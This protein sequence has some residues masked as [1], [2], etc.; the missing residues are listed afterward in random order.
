VEK[1]WKETSW[2]RTC[3]SLDYNK[4]KSIKGT[5]FSVKRDERSNKNILVGTY[6]DRDNFGARFQVVLA[7]ESSESLNW[8]ADQLNQKYRE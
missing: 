2:I 4:Q 7:D 3:S 6:L 8:A 5:G 1:V